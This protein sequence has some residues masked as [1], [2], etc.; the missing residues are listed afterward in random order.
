MKSKV[1]IE[2]NITD[3]VKMDLAVFGVGVWGSGAMVILDL[4]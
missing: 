3:C 1:Q 2:I 4:L